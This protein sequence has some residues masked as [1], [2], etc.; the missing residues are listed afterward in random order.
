M[1]AVIGHGQLN[2]DDQS[3]SVASSLASARDICSPSVSG[4][5]LIFGADRAF[6]GPLL[7]RLPHEKKPGVEPGQKCMRNCWR[8]I[9]LSVAVFEGDD[10]GVTE[11]AR[12]GAYDFRRQPQVAGMLRAIVG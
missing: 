2:G 10:V 1:R 6:V 8:P 7:A 11:A 4:P 5:E 9:E 12:H 3:G